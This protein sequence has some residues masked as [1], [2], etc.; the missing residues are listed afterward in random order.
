MTCNLERIERSLVSA[1]IY[2]R[3]KL[4]Y[5]SSQVIGIAVLNLNFAR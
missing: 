5:P 2:L 1:T 4:N 3:K